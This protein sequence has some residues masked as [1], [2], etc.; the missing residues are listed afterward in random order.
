[1]R[2]RYERKKEECKDLIRMIQVVSSGLIFFRKMNF[3]LR[4]RL[5]WKNS[6]LRRV[7]GAYIDRKISMIF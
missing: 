6:L 2:L 1:M 4:W 5:G 7:M 3:Y